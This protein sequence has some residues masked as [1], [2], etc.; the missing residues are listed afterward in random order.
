ME[1]TD[2]SQISA[3][4]KRPGAPVI[5]PRNTPNTRK[6]DGDGAFKEFGLT[7]FLSCISWLE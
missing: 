4:A 1:L 3:G 2:F 6:E 7:A 5:E